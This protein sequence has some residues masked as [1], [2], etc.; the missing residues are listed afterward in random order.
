[1]Q[2][3]EAAKP[4]TIA[5]AAAS[6]RALRHKM[7]QYFSLFKVFCIALIVTQQGLTT[8]DRATPK[9]GDASFVLVEDFYGVQ[10]RAAA[11]VFFQ[12]NR[13]QFIATL[14][15]PQK[16]NAPGR[17]NRHIIVGIAGESERRIGKRKNEAAVADV[18]TIK[19]LITHLH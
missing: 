13:T 17:G 2:L 11:A 16:F 18:E 6:Y 14:G 19:H 5:R 3:C 12:R 7:S 1:M 10:T 15:R 4:A 8:A 9:H